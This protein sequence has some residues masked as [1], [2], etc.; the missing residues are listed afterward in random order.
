MTATDKPKES[1]PVPSIELT[2]IGEQY[3]IPGCERDATR[4]PK[5]SD[6]WGRD[7]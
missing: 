3:V 4:G 6:L 7:K 2:D 1:P 5:Q